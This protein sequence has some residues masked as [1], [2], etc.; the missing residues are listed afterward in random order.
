MCQRSNWGGITLDIKI[1]IDPMVWERKYFTVASPLFISLFLK[2]IGI[3]AIAFISRAN[4]EIRKEGEDIIKKILVNRI[5]EN[6]KV[7]GSMK[8]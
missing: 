1:Q 4:H 5:R 8:I 7:A 6:N 3:N 2:I